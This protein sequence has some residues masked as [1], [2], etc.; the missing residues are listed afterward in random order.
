MITETVPVLQQAAQPVAP[1]ATQEGEGGDVVMSP[2]NGDVGD[3]GGGATAQEDEDMEDGAYTV[4]SMT[5]LV[6]PICAPVCGWWCK[7]YSRVREDP[8]WKLHSRLSVQ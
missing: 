8:A 2:V 7:A 6:L 3:E 5:R 1:K 4:W